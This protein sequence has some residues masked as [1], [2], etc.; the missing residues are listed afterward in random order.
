MGEN[1]N[2]VVVLWICLFVIPMGVKFFFLYFRRHIS[3]KFKVSLC[4]KKG[5][6]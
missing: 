6:S 5:H 2:S 3:S 1:Q 4:T